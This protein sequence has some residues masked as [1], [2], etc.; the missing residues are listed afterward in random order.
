[1]HFS[2]HKIHVKPNEFYSI[3][4]LIAVWNTQ[5]PMTSHKLA[6]LDTSVCWQTLSGIL[7]TTTPNPNPYPNFKHNLNPYTDLENST[8]FG[9]GHVILLLLLTSPLLQE[10]SLPCFLL[11]RQMLKRRWERLTCLILIYEDEIHHKIH[12]ICLTYMVA[13]AYNFHYC[14][15]LYLRKTM[16]KHLINEEFVK[17]LITYQNNRLILHMCC[18]PLLHNFTAVRQHILLFE[19]SRV[20]AFSEIH[21]SRKLV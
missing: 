4:D 7:G 8:D 13:F 1:M 20:L 5:Y 14:V 11:T 6:Q 18:T 12:F 16:S 2:Y 15:Y 17:T 19:F 9:H 21:L 3:K 10:R